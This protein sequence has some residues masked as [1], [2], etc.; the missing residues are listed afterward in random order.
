MDNTINTAVNYVN[1]NKTKFLSELNELIRIPSISTDLSHKQDMDK[2]ADWLKSKLNTLGF[3]A[4]VMQTA[5]HP[6][7]FGEYI[8][9]STLPTILIYGHYDVQPADPLDQWQSDPFLGDVRDGCIY[10]RGASDMKGQILASMFALESLL[11]KSTIPFNIKYI[12]EGEEEI[13][14]PSLRTFLCNYSKELA[15]DVVLNPDTGMVNKHQP[16]ITYGLRGLAYFELHVYGP[17]HDLHSGLFGGVIHNPAQV[18][19]QLI[20]EMHDPQGRITLPEFYKN[21]RLITVEDK[22]DIN[23]IA[24]DDDLIKQQTG[25]PALWGEEGYSAAERIGARPTLD[26]NGM[27]SGFTG[28]GSKTIIPSSAMAK[29]S[30]RLVPDQIPSEI[31][32]S[33]IKYM[34]EKAPSS[35]RWEIKMLS[36]GPASLSNRN[37]PATKAMTKAMKA[38]WGIEPIF[39]REGGSV[40]VTADMQEILDIDSVLIGFGLPDDNIHAPN[41][42]LDLETWYKGIETLIHFFCY[43]NDF[44]SGGA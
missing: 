22:L 21:V 36:G 31:H 19:C 17:D 39:K 14:S 25:V 38:V 8:I 26:I 7:V 27:L 13:G 35:V 23:K 18:L 1:T 11:D 28:A 20:S 2:A 37:L 12:L 15:S 42:K 16:T 32:K 9:S 29:I 44:Y 4:N 30:M 34:Q 6:I 10:G 3:T 43:M 33:L 40:P 41:E 5:L 24:L